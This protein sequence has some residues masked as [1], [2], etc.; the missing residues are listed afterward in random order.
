MRVRGDPGD[1]VDEEAARGH[2]DRGFGLRGRDR[3]RNARDGQGRGESGGGFLLSLLRVTGEGAVGWGNGDGVVV[4]DIGVSNVANGR[5][6][7]GS[8]T[9]HVVVEVL[10]GGDTI[11]A[12]LLPGRVP[13]FRVDGG[14]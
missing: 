14:G 9:G 11:L 12:A 8:R 10:V 4:D 13:R 1:G 6:F 7:D 5:V 2:V 3:E